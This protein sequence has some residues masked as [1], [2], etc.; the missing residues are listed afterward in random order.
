VLNSTSR[1]RIVFGLLKIPSANGPRTTTRSFL[2]RTI[3]F[4]VSSRSSSPRFRRWKTTVFRIVRYTS[5]F[6]RRVKICGPRRRVSITAADPTQSLIKYRRT[7]STDESVTPCHSVIT[8]YSHVRIVC[9]TCIIRLFRTFLFKTVVRIIRQPFEFT[10]F[11]VFTRFPETIVHL[12]FYRTRKI[13]Y[14][15]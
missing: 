5:L 11:Y 8:Y 3:L 1:D 4:S 2:A 15:F 12:S 6:I 9:V 14:G 13:L 10:C 7:G